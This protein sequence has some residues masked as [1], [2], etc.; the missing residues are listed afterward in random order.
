M[1]GTQN[2]G[3][4]IKE[5]RH[6]EEQDHV[7]ESITSLSSHYYCKVLEKS[8]MDPSTRPRQSSWSRVERREVRKIEKPPM[9]ECMTVGM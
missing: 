5:D 6:Q 9:N 3:G 2:V 7:D 1:A 8:V 4:S